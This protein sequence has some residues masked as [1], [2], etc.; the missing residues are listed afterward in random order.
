[1]KILSF[2]LLLLSGS[3]LAQTTITVPLDIVNA[4]PPKR[5]SQIGTGQSSDITAFRGVP[6]N[7]TEKV[8]RTANTA[9]GQS[10]YELFL[11]GE[12][13]KADW[14]QKKRMVGGD[15]I[16]LSP[17]PLKQQ[18]NMLVGTNTVGQRVV[19]VDANSNRDFS[20][21]RA[22]TYPMILPQIPKS[23]KGFY[24]N[25][26]HAVFDTLPAVAVTVEAF[27]GRQIVQRTVSFKPIPYNTGWT[28]PK[29]EENQFHL[30]L[31]AH[32]YRQA[33]T[34]LAGKSVQVFIMTAPGTPYVLESATIEVSEVGQTPIKRFTHSAFNK[35]SIFILGD[36][37]LEIT[38]LSRQGDQ[39]TLLDKGVIT[40]TR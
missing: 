27:D 2:A 34:T 36:H 12:M 14:E 25:S 31:L 35:D 26:I 19:I 33:T 22:F 18:I 5:Y 6:T 37:V 1:M 7:L 28:Y 23:E 17:T 13:S 15:T 10:S 30:A 11:R 4:A 9:S 39:L 20:D 8:I 21:D 38:G 3:V 29:P 24:D 32:E 40:P 16:Y